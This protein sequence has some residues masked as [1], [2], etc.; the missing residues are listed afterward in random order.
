MK[1]DASF[2]MLHTELLA[3][4][5]HLINSNYEFLI[6]THFLLLFPNKFHGL[7]S[8]VEVLSPQDFSM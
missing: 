4:M 2:K 8:Y 6:K 3:W 1:K 7:K 5:S